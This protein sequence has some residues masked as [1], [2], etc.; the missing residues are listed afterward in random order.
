MIDGDG[1]VVNGHI[2]VFPT[3]LPVRVSDLLDYFQPSQMLFILESPL[4][5]L[6]CLS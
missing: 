4:Q 5:F 1:A 6:S 3:P 2:A